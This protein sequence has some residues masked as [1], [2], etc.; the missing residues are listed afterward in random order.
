MHNSKKETDR[1]NERIIPN[2]EIKIVDLNL[3][4]AIPSIC[5]IIVNGKPGG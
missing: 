2:S 1:I 3:V 4:K 5:K